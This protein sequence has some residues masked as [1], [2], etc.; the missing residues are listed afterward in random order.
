MSAI[1]AAYEEAVSTVESCAKKFHRAYNDIADKVDLA[2]K[3][4]PGQLEQRIREAMAEF[5]AE[6]RKS[7]VLFA[8]LWLE[9][10]SA[11][12]LRD[13]GSEWNLQVKAVASDHSVRI[14]FP[15]LPSKEAWRG[16]AQIAYRTVVDQQSKM[17]GDFVTQIDDLND[18]LNDLADALKYYWV[19]IA[20][21]ATA[22][23]GVLAACAV[24]STLVVSIP[25]TIVGAIAA[26]VGFW[27][28]VA[29]ATVLYH[30]VLDANK[31]KLEKIRA[32]YG[33]AGEWPKAS[34]GNG[35]TAGWEPNP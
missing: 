6:H 1:D 9:R 5:T 26:I 7:E 3:F 25:A 20:L 31:A 16:T 4:V 18:V 15:Q 29:G 30:N 2:L 33:T 10:G 8:D 12:A 21:E 32:V 34:V 17:L 11:G 35:S 19:S 27:A 23:A 13:A 22:C 28:F 14:S 24:A